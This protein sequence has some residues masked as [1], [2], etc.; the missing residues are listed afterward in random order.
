MAPYTKNAN[1][2]ATERAE[3]GDDAC[4]ETALFYVWNS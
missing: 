1:D 4:E 3:D 2:N